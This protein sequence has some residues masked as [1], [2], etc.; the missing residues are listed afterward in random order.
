[1]LLLTITLGTIS[2]VL[3]IREERL[4]V[5]HI[6]MGL[7]LVFVTILIRQEP[8]LNMLLLDAIS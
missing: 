8:V 7:L 6:R 4:L 5:W 1:M 3:V 2:C